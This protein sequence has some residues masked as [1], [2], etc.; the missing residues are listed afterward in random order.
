MSLRKKRDGEKEI[1]VRRRSKKSH[2][3]G[4][5]GAWKVAF[6]DFTL[7]M[8]AL[9]MVL[10][11]INPSKSS[12][13]ITA[14]DPVSNPLMEGMINIFDGFEAPVEL[15]A[16]PSA[17]EQV[18]EEKAAD[19]QVEEEP[20]PSKIYRTRQELEQLAELLDVLSGKLDALTNLEVA[21]VPQGL[22]IL[23][24]DDE[25]RYMFER[26]SARLNPHFNTLLGN[27]AEVLVKVENRIIISGHTDATQYRRSALYNNWNLSGDRALVARNVLVQSGL[28]G[29]R[30]LQVTAL[31][32]VMPLNPMEPTDGINR[33]IELLLLTER[34]E[35]LYRELFGESYP[36]A[37][38]NRQL[39]PAGT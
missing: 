32:D 18:V 38:L 35:V 25:Q 16:R 15:E 20:I 13:P 8:M 2:G 28:P 19:E 9:F 22:R 29:E 34:A 1:V 30:I 6:A 14:D 37:R 5:S 11:I 21:V 7:A 33:R 3:D 39:A 26:G 24:K 27:L 36:Q 10:W 12:M 17:P 23:I 4:H 31:A